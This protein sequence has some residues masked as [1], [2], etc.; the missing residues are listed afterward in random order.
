MINENGY[1]GHGADKVV[2][3]RVV[4]KKKKVTQC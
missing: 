2:M 3:K 1:G 4:G